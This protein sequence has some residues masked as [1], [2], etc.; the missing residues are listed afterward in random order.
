[1]KKKLVISVIILLVIGLLSGMLYGYHQW[2]K[3]RNEKI[4]QIILSIEYREQNT[5]FGMSIND[6]ELG[7]QE[8]NKVNEKELYVR[9]EVYNSWNKQQNNGREVL[10]LTDIEDYLSSEYNE[11][12]SLRV[13]SR[14]E[15]IQ[16]YM[17]WYYADGN[18]DVDE[19][20]DGLQEIVMNFYDEH[21]EI[22]KKTT[23]NMDTEQLQEL[24]NKYNNPDY[25]INADIMGGKE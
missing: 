3:A 23:G 15:K 13:Y 4:E 22:S 1:M 14:P 20:W 6:S 17:K 24:I 5:A 9:L 18:R 7:Y 12:G 25:E 8:Y 2:K 21:P 16:E 10:Y 19:Y 11:D